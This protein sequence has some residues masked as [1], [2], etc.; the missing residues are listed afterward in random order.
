MVRAPILSLELREDDRSADAV[1]M[2]IPIPDLNLQPPERAI[3]WAMW[4]KA[5]ELRNRH[6]HLPRTISEEP[7]RSVRSE[8]DRPC[9]SDTSSIDQIEMKY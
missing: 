2:S 1:S 8:S 7:Y 4:W 5:V 9:T 6:R 3:A